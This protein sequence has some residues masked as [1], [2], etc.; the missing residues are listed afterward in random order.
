MISAQ[1][2]KIRVSTEERISQLK[3]INLILNKLKE[4][5]CIRYMSQD[6]QDS[7]AEAKVI[8][9]DIAWENERDLIN[10]EEFL[11]VREARNEP[12]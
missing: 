7:I 11:K 8:L 1:F 4:D 5:P 12:F 10:L 3:K 9:H 2:E 6:S